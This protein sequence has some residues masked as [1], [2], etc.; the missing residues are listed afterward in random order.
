MTSMQ[1]ENV[2]GESDFHSLTRWLMSNTKDKELTVLMSQM[3][4]ACKATSR[5]CCKAGI[6]NPF[7][8]AG[9]VNSTGDDQKKLDVLSNDIFINALVNCGACCALVS[10]ENE[11][12]I[13]VS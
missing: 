4:L 11:E 3:A 8:L 1:V 2:A 5:A 10:E 9:E 7:G 12:P 6:A 13:W